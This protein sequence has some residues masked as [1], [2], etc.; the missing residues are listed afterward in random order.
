ME[1][2]AAKRITHSTRGVPPPYRSPASWL[3]ALR[4]ADREAIRLAYTWYLPLLT[5]QARKL[6]V[7]RAE[8]GD[9]AATVLADVLLHLM[10]TDVPPRDFVGYLVGALRN[11]ARK[12]YRARRRLLA[13]EE[14]AYQRHGDG[15]ERIVAEC[16]SE[17]G[18]RA[19]NAEPSAEGGTDGVASLRSAVRKLAERS[20]QALTDLELGLLVGQAHHIPLR[21]LAEQVGITHGAARVRVHRLREKLHK[22]ALQH[23]PLLDDDERRELRRFLRRAGI[24]LETDSAVPHGRRPSCRDGAT[25]EEPDDTR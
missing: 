1:D 8:C 23:D 12:E 3:S 19:S 25:G 2:G 6:G 9:L 7:G 22:L 4:N 14:G 15:R 10:R 13:R 20:A 11:R 24:M 18:L 5:D 21:E 17:Y 16:H